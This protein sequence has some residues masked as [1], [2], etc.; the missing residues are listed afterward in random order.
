[1]IPLR[2]GLLNCRAQRHEYEHNSNISHTNFA[3]GFD[4]NREIFK[5]AMA[6]N[7][8]LLSFV[9]TQ[10]CKGAGTIL[11]DLVSFMAR[12]EST[13]RKILFETILDIG[14]PCV[15]SDL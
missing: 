1:V 6:V 5:S 9:G 8:V 11:P 4:E 14:I 10:I 15:H 12:R 7:N 13:A 2:K 3:I